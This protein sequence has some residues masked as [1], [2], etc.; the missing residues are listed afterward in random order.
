MQQFLLTLISTYIITISFNDKI[1]TSMEYDALL[2][3]NYNY[4]K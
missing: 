1:I 4:Y 2:F 3:I